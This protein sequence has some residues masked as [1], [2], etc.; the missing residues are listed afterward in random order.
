MPFIGG[1]HAGA[2]AV[3]LQTGQAAAAL[4][5]GVHETADPDVI[6]DLVLGD[7]RTDSSHHARD[8]MTGD[9]RIVG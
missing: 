7:L 5:A 3:L 6:A 1:D 9:Y 2:L 8:L 4:A